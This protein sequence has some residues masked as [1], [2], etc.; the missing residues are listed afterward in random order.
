EQASLQVRQSIVN[1]ML[2][3]YRDLTLLLPGEKGFLTEESVALNLSYWVY[4]ALNHFAQSN[5]QFGEVR[6]SGLAL[7]K[8]AKFGRWQLPA[9]WILVS[10]DPEK[11][12][13]PWQQSSQRY[14]YDAVRIPLYLK[15]A[16]HASSELVA[17]YAKFVH[18]FCAFELLPDWVDLT[19]ETV[20]MNSA[21]A[22]MRAIY[23][24]LLG[25]SARDCEFNQYVSEPNYYSDVLALLVQAAEQIAM[26][27]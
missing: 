27:R 12:I 11:S 25:D 16:G 8:Q 23:H 7:L 13:Q 2:Y 5:A 24:Y 20:H 21:D 1:K 19:A 3:S 15:W 22:G 17:P 26:A 6:D 9:D 14:G 10:F 18:S 4:P